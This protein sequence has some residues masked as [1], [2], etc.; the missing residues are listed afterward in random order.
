MNRCSL[1]CK[2]WVGKN[3]FPSYNLA[4]I[5]SM[6]HEAF[7]VIKCKGY[8]EICWAIKGISRGPEAL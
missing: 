7:S 3:H 4:M 5:T 6:I 2:E 8:G 1:K